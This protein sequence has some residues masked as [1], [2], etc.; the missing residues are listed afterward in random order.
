MN[1]IVNKTDWEFLRIWQRDVSLVREEV[2]N[3]WRTYAKLPEEEIQKRIHELILV[4]KFQGKIVGVSTAYIQPVKLLN[5]HDFAFYRNFVVSQ[6]RIA[7]L[8]FAITKESV[9]TLEEAY[10]QTENQRVKGVITILENNDL[11]TSPTMKKAVWVNVPFVFIG[12]TS[13]GHPIRVYYFKN[14]RI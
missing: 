14:A 11:K 6:F 3:L 2:E 1:G 9:A 10:P 4:V 8:D 13:A 12:N 7:G 5:N